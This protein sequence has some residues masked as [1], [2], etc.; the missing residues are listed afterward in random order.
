MKRLALLF[1]VACSSSKPTPESPGPITASLLDCE[2][3]A[4]HVATTVVADKPRAGVTHATVKELVSTRCQADKWT[5]ET[6][7][8][9]NTIATIKDGRACATQMTDEQRISIRTAARVLRKD[10]APGDP[11]PGSDWIRHVVEEPAP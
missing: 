11:D 8:C 5:D 2:K 9:L 1:V 4:E 10:P 3:V 6:K 7:Q